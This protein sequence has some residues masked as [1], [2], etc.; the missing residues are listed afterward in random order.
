[1]RRFTIEEGR[2]LFRS[3]NG[4]LNTSALRYLLGQ[5][6]REGGGGVRRKLEGVSG[7]AA[8]CRDNVK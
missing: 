8:H 6:G 2:N 4:A 7:D 3:P 1:M 5:L